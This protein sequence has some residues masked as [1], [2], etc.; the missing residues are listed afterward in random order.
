VLAAGKGVFGKLA[1]TCGTDVTTLIGM[2]MVLSLPVF[3]LVAW[4]AQRSSS[5]PASPSHVVSA[6]ALG[7]L[8]Y[9]VASWLD[10]L[11]LERVDAAVERVVL[12]AYPT[13]VVLA[14]WV[15]R[16]SFDKR[17]LLALLATYTGVGLT[18]SGQAAIGHADA[19]GVGLIAASSLVYAFFLIGADDLIKTLGAV[20]FMALAMIGACVTGIAHAVSTRS[21]ELLEASPAAWEMAAGVAYVC[22]VLPA[23]LLAAGMRELGAARFATISSIGPAATAGLAWLFLGEALTITA[24]IGMGITVVGAAFVSY[25]KLDSFTK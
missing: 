22:T 5:Q 23:F 1:Y 10:F 16:R 19:I 8:G 20:R 7:V 15:R 25:G 21:N 6:A 3:L 14:V 2:R 4:H 13:F 12:Y 24:V 18:W 17:V 11:G 9:H